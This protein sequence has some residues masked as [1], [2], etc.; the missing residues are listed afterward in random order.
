MP[1]IKHEAAARI[2][3]EDPQLVAMLL[4]MCGVVLPSGAIPIAADTPAST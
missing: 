3:R 1:S 4:G 2:L